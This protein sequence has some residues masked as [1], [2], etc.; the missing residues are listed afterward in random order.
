MDPEIL[1]E[2]KVATG[3]KKDLKDELQLSGRNEVKDYIKY[4]PVGQVKWG[5]GG[6]QREQQT[7]Q[8]P[9]R[10]LYDQDGKPIPPSGSSGTNL[11]PNQTP[12]KPANPAG[13]GPEE[14]T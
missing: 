2:L 13:D 8:Q 14:T 3:D 6:S 11:N 12:G 10:T 1:N 7:Q 4:N 5:A 9:Q